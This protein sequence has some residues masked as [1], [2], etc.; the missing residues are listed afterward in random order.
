MRWILVFLIEIIP[1]IL[2]DVGIFVW[3]P[4]Y[5]SWRH[6]L[7]YEIEYITLHFHRINQIRACHRWI[8]TSTQTL[9]LHPTITHYDIPSFARWLRLKLHSAIATAAWWMKYKRWISW[10]R[11]KKII[12]TTIAWGI[13]DQMKKEILKQETGIKD[14]FICIQCYIKTRGNKKSCVKTRRLGNYL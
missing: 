1:F 7:I 6:V 14:V 11:Q 5:I 13:D 10:K 9:C 4:S 8:E 3:V 12:K 2:I